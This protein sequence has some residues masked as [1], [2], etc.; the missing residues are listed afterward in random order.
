MTIREIINTLEAFAPLDLQEDFD[1]A[2]VQVAVNSCP[3][4]LDAQLTGVLV[5]LD[6]TEQ[7][8]DEAIAKNCNM[9]VSHHPLIFQPLKRVCGQ[10]YQQRCV[11]KAILAGITLYSAHTNL[12]NARGGVNHIIASM[13]G[14]NNL[15]WLEPRGS[16]G[17]SGVIGELPVPMTAMQLL[18]S[19]KT[20]F[21]VDALFNNCRGN[22]AF[23]EQKSVCGTI[24]VE[25]E[26]RKVALCGGAGAFLMGKAREMGADAFITGEIH[27]H[28][29]FGQDMLLVEMGHYQS[30]Q[31]TQELLMKIILRNFPE[32]RV[33]K[34]SVNTNPVLTI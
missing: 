19:L 1:N 23:A 8:I 4:A 14:L 32:A 25:K 21:K 12:D 10:T 5:C 17:G 16:E 15:Q 7:V 33:M 30:E 2:G 6:I 31:Y 18:L 3:D 24:A 29:Y 34:T 28:D 27:Y 26:I 9:V 11:A 20:L 22:S 13:L